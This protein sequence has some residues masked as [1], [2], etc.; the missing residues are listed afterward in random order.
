M[1]KR[2]PP[3][4]PLRAFE[5]TARYLSVS[6][7]AA[8]L[9]V[10]PGAVSHQIRALEEA[11]KVSL[12]H[13]DAGRLRLSSHGS[14][15]H[16]AIATAF[17]S[18]AE[19]SALLTRQKTEGD[20]VVSCVPALA[21]FWLIPHLGGFAKRYPGIQL[22]LMASN[23]DADI[24]S[25]DVDLCIRYGNG[26]WPDRHVQLWTQMMLFPVCSPTLV[27]AKPLRDVSDL[28][29]HT[30]LHGDDGRE[31]QNWLSVA[32]APSISGVRSYNMSDAHLAIEAAIHGHGVALGDSITTS[33]LLAEGKLIAPFALKV[34]APAAFYIVCRNELRNAPIVN[35]FTDWMASEIAPGKRI[36]AQKRART[37]APKSKARKKAG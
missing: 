35:A 34:P 13:R 9:N 16:P 24:A 30:I 32:R 14:A 26:A 18:I 19:A 23:D 25:P 15:L 29:H 20:L 6:R 5:A 28:L 12:F 21:S 10:T 27:N 31:W 8:E 37:P 22:K 4:N 7:A 2:L 33:R 1:R 3:L 36:P 11:L 17:D